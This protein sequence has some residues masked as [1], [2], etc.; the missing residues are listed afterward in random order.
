ML[1]KLDVLSDV[2]RARDGWWAAYRDALWSGEDMDAWLSANPM[3]GPADVAEM[4]RAALTA[5]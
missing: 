2:D 1:V 4:V 5:G 3:P